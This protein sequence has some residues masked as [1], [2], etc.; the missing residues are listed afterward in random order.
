MASSIS[1]VRLEAEAQVAVLHQVLQALLAQEAVDEGHALREVVVEDDPAHGGV[2]DL[3]LDDLDLGV[4]HV[5]V[6]VDRGQVDELAR[7]HEADRG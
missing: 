5:L 3:V 4:D 6:V 1:T 7:V 2:D